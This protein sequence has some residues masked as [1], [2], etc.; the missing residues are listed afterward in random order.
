MLGGRKQQILVWMLI[1]AVAVYLLERLFF[2]TALFG[3]PLLLFSLAWLVSLILK[4]LVDWLTL[5]T[6]PVPFVSREGRPSAPPESD[7]RTPPATCALASTSKNIE[8]E[9]N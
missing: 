4:P 2:L 6:L 9:R 1:V 5:L 7:G 3:T 8:P